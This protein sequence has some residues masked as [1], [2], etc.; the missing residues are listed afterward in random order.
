MKSP[1]VPTFQPR[2]ADDLRRQ[3]QEPA[4]VALDAK[5]RSLVLAAIG[6]ATRAD[7]TGLHR[8]AAIFG[9]STFVLAVQ[10]LEQ[11]SRVQGAVAAQR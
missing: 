7:D 1:P 11:Q 4:P 5:V 8:I 3:L 9:G 6:A 2:L 10:G